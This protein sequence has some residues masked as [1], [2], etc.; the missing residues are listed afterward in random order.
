MIVVP[1]GPPGSLEVADV[2]SDEVTLNWAKPRKDGGSKITGYV[3]EYK[4]ANS[5]E[6]IKGPTTKEPTA[7]VSGLRKG[8]KYNFRVSAKNSAGTG[9]PSQATRPVLCKPKY[10]ELVTSSIGARIEPSTICPN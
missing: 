3:V 2:D 4:P 7:T 6:W 8:E 10:G 9:E 5:D 1:P